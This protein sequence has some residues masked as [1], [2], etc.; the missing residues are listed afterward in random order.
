MALTLLSKRSSLLLLLLILVLA[1]AG[2]LRL[3]Q[4]DSIPPGLY[5]DEALNANQAL[6]IAATGEHRVFFPENNGRE[7][8]FFSLVSF[9]FVLFGVSVFS[10]KLVGA[11]AGILTVLGQY[12]LSREFFQGL[13]KRLPLARSM[14]LLSAFFLAVSFWHINFS[15]I[16]FRG[17]LT[18]LALVFSF[19]FLLRGLRTK[20]LQDFLFSGLLF[21]AGFST[22]ISFRVA[23]LPLAFLLAMGLILAI[24]QKWGKRYIIGTALLLVACLLTA[25]PLAFYFLEHPEY[26]FSRAT[27][28]SVFSTE[29][30]IFAFAKSL[31]Q[32]L[33]MFN[34]QGDTNW[35]HNFAGAPQLFW[36]VGFLFLVGL[37][38]SVWR[39]GRA[40]ALLFF[41][42]EKTREVLLPFALHGFLLAWFFALLLPGALT[43]EGAPHALRV[44]GAIPP[45]YLLAAFGACLVWE[46][47]SRFCRP[48]ALVLLVLLV[49]GS[50]GA[51]FHKYFN[52][53]ASRPEVQGAFTKRFVDVGTILNELPEEKIAY[54][55]KTEGDLPTETVKFVQA[56][57]GR[58]NARFL[59]KEELSSFPFRPGDLV[60]FMNKDWENA[61]E[62]QNRFPKAI[63]KEYERFLLFEL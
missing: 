38:A 15:R 3:W 7:G 58:E 1:L 45:V 21:G 27:G 53:W 60:F 44:I 10:F 37:G 32:H 34:F 48:A 59:E 13:G 8:L 50:T 63:L 28:V 35:R 23:V 57:A 12:L 56:A 9:S 43:F 26:F 30:P 6:E 16:G 4:L 62:F 52:S 40:K 24:Q 51:T 29:N 41:Q 18:P 2:F 19:F 17:I 36:P 46:R 49:A 31:G 5:P 22:Y 14:A 11:L 47:L 33:V 55:A 25:L 54:V 61:E 42:R 20:R 39:L